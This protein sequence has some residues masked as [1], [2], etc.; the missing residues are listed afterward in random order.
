MP[1]AATLGPRS[2]PA[3]YPDAGIAL[4]GRR[5]HELTPGWVPRKTPILWG[6]PRPSSCRRIGATTTPRPASTRP[7]G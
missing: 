6:E 3:E 1:V 4:R 2:L 7:D 5:W